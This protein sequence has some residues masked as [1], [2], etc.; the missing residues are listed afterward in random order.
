MRTDQPTTETPADQR[1]AAI[2]EAAIREVIEALENDIDA[3]DAAG[4][5]VFA[6]AEFVRRRFG[7]AD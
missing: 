4:G 5:E 2:R 1:D 7:I 3:F 6:A